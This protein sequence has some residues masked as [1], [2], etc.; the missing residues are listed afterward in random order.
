M[1]IREMLMLDR[2]LLK[3]ICTVIRFPQMTEQNDM[4]HVVEERENHE[5]SITTK[6]LIR[7][8][9]IALHPDFN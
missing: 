8:T 3:V 9:D 6:I 7:K 1:K 5:T 4:I 2:N